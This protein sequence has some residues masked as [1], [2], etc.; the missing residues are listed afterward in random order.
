MSIA[1]HLLLCFAYHV[2]FCHHANLEE[3]KE[4]VIT[5][6][7]TYTRTYEHK[8]ADTYIKFLQTTQNY[9]RCSRLDAFEPSKE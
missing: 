2:V 4:C 9:A 6:A 5:D 8:S 7:Y 1:S 3:T